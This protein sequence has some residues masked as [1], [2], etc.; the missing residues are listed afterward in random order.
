MRVPVQRIHPLLVREANEDDRSPFFFGGGR[1][2]G[3]M[4][5]GPNLPRKAIDAVSGSSPQNVHSIHHNHT[6]GV[7]LN[8]YHRSVPKYEFSYDYSL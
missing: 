6:L 4:V 5:K 7:E 1:R 8:F 2:N 3:R